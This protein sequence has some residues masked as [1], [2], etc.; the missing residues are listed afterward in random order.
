MDE[1]MTG[2]PW[3]DSA[4]LLRLRGCIHLWVGDLSMPTEWPRSTDDEASML[5][6]MS[7]DRG[8]VAARAREEDDRR[9]ATEVGKLR[10]KQMRHEAH[11]TFVQA[12]RR[13][14]RC[15]EIEMDEDRDEDDT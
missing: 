6:R 2:P 12:E 14:A 11:L 10:R 4:T 1:L 7:R 9:R 3:A 5:D 13:G 8:K 15:P